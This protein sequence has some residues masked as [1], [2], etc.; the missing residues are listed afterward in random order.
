M[1]RRPLRVT[2][3]AGQLYATRSAACVRHSRERSPRAK[4]ENVTQVRAAAGQRQQDLA[5]GLLRHRGGGGARRGQVRALCGRLAGRQAGVPH[6]QGTSAAMGACAALRRYLYKLEGPKACTF[7]VAA[8]MA[9]ELD[10]LTVEQL[11][12]QF[13]RVLSATVPSRETLCAS[14]PT[15]PPST[16]L[17]HAGWGHLPCAALP[18]AGQRLH[19]HATHAG[20]PAAGPGPLRRI[21]RAPRAASATSTGAAGTTAG[22]A[23]CRSPCRTAGP[24]ASSSASPSTRSTPPSACTPP[25]LCWARGARGVCPPACATRACSA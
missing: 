13:R 10:S 6:V 1:V 4:R 12:H 14:R 17:A 20:V 9:A 11:R 25:P 23:T 21:G 18:R 24:S 15:P 19:T 5:H 22:R 16:T 2:L 8:R 3:G 7:P